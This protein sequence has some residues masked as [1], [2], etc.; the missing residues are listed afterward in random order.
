MNYD[1]FVIIHSHFFLFFIIAHQFKTCWNNYYKTK[2]NLVRVSSCQSYPRSVF[3]SLTPG[4]SHFLTGVLY[5]IIILN[6]QGFL[7]KN[8]QY[9][10]ARVFPYGGY[11]IKSAGKKDV[12]TRLEAENV[13]LESLPDETTKVKTVE[14]LQQY[15]T[16]GYKA[17]PLQMPVLLLTGN[18]TPVWEL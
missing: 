17:T 16:R 12:K 8:K 18:L 10:V 7:Q 2:R 6:S 15:V 3:I 14:E 9:P 5:V 1:Y 4:S 13:A 11:K